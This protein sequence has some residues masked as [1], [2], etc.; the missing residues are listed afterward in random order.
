MKKALRL[1]VWILISVASVVLVAFLAGK[2]PSS[3]KQMVNSAL[4]EALEQDETR[5]VSEV[6]SIVQ[7]AESSRQKVIDDSIAVS[8][9]ESVSEQ[10]SIAESLSVEASVAESI[11]ASIEAS[12]EA[13]VAESV[14]ASVGEEEARKARSAAQEAARRAEAARLAFIAAQTTD[15]SGT[16]GLT[17]LYGD[18]RTKAFPVLGL[19]DANLVYYTTNQIGA[20]DE[21]AAAQR[22]ASLYP[23]KIVF[24][25]GIDD[26]CVR[27][28]ANARNE[29]ERMILMFH[30]L[31]PATRIY[32]HSV[33]PVQEWRMQDNVNPGLRGIPE[34]NALLV[35]MCARHGWT[36]ID[37]SQGVSFAT[38]S[39]DQGFI[40]GATKPDGIHFTPQFTY[41]WF[42]NIRRTVGF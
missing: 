30:E 35:D 32:V 16:T 8:V 17:Y 20:T 42:G 37:C 39:P 31:S 21:F 29:Y 13:S 18:S 34:F 26:L 14:A 5:A 23:A 10:E 2:N 1:T 40:F 4:K 25:N 24:L 9:S 36:F 6:A 33:L 41:L 38:D 7:S 27:T 11:A 19:Y 22:A 3:A 28:P 12:V 15:A